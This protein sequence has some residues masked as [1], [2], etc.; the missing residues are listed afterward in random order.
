V[1]GNEDNLRDYWTKDPPRLSGE[2][3]PW[4]LFAFEREQPDTRGHEKRS[5]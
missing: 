2:E 3:T 5:A 1:A 4:G